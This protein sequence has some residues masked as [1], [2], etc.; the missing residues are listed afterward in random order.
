M[1]IRSSPPPPGQEP[2]PPPLAYAMNSDPDAA[3]VP[4]INFCP[5]F[6]NRRSLADGIT[7]GLAQRNPGNLDLSN[8][9]NRAQTFFVS[10]FSQR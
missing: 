5:G 6:H 10:T 3:G 9:D 8:Y 4:M 1:L 2:K 7:Y